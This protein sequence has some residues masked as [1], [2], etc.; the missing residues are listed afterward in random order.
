MLFEA[1]FEAL[2]YKT[3]FKKIIV[4]QNLE[5]ARACCTPCASATE[6]LL[7]FTHYFYEPGFVCMDDASLE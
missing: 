6:Y 4:D 2:W 3:E 7:Y 5:G 1:C